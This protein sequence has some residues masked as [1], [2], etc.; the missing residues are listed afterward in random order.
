[1]T[2]AQHNRAEAQGVGGLFFKRSGVDR[3]TGEDRRQVHDLSYFEQGG[4][5]RRSGK[6]RRSLV[7]RRAGWVRLSDWHSVCIQPER[8]LA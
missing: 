8:A 6:E 3:R 7:E 2:A 1:M 5:E 4:V